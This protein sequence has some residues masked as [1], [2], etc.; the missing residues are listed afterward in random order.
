M[1]RFSYSF[2]KFIWSLTWDIKGLCLFIQKIFF[3]K[4]GVEYV[5]QTI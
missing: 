4:W 1:N 5:K 3:Q 2:A